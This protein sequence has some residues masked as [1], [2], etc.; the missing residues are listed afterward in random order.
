MII[1][2][3]AIEIF[4]HGTD[5]KHYESIDTEA[6]FHSDTVLAE[7]FLPDREYQFFVISE[8]VR[9]VLHRV[10]AKVKGDRISSI[11]TLV[12]LKNKDPRHGREYI[13]PL[14]RLN[15]GT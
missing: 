13:S 2:G 4:P 6:F 7:E 12:Q 11:S 14:E 5:R 8:Y 9:A 1:L 10:P 15:P 3:K